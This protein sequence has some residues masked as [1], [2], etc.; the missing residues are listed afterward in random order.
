MTTA[1]NE[2]SSI[3]IEKVGEWLMRSALAGSDLETL[4]GGFCERLAA[5]GL[6]LA[7]IHLSFSV[8]H[9]LYRAAGFT[10]Y[11]GTGVKQESYRHAENQFSDVFTK[12]PYYYLLK[13]DIPYIHR[14][15]TPSAQLDFTILEDLRREG[16]TDYL[17]FVQLFDKGSSK[18]M[19]GSW[20]T[21]DKNGF[22]DSVISALL[23]VQNQLAVATRMAVLSKLADN[24]LST[25]LGEVAGRRV[26]SGQIK[27]GDGETI[28]AAVVM[29]DMRNSTEM[30]EKEGRRVFI[31]TLNQFFDAIAVPFHG[32][33]GQILSFMGDGFLAVYPC[34]RQREQSETA[35]RAALAA[36]NAATAAMAKL[37]QGRIASGLEPIG[38]GIGL[39]IGNVIFGNV[40]LKDRLT[41][42][43][44]GLAV[45]QAQRLEALTR[46][47]PAEIIASEEFV[48][49]C[50][51]QWTKLGTEVL[52]GIEDP[53]N[54]YAPPTE[55]LVSRD[56]PLSIGEPDELSDAEHLVILHQGKPVTA[57]EEHT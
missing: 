44:F 56:M 40:G 13:N 42:S 19:M 14:R 38:F 28:R 21:D 46:R 49:Y 20:S 36:A 5:A 35:C 3:L 1:Q 32:N 52:R 45:H 37:N 2:V 7:R 26:L 12:S 9:P 48:N 18:A 43:A 34:E 47:Y 24:L 23:Q 50:G 25:Y 51:G 53:V 8:L 57:D 6:P 17:A 39:H 54:V 30:V 22:S 33:S 10:W 55:N 11:R 41:F 31:R 4:V 27:R 29:A 15:I 16:M